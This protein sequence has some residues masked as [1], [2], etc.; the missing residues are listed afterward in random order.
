M[1]IITQKQISDLN[2]SPKD[3]VEWVKGSFAAK[4]KSNLPAKTCLYT[5]DIDFFTTM[6]CVLFEQNR[7]GVKVVHR[8]SGAVPALGSDLM[9]YDLSNGDLLAIMDANWITAMR[10]GA[11]ATLAAQT[12][13]R[14]GQVT[15]GFMGLGNTARASMLCLL[16]SEPDIMHNVNLLK[17][18]NQE[19]DFIK[20]FEGYSNVSFSFYGDVR[21][22]ISSTDVL[23]SCITEAKTL[24]C[25]DDQAY[26]KGCLLIP[27]HTRGFQN[28]D[29]TF[30]KIFADD[31]QHVKGF[32]YFSQFRRYAEIQDVLSGKV[33]GRENDS[34]RIISY[35][36]GLG[37]HDVYFASRIFDLLK[38]NS[39]D[40]PFIKETE[41]FWI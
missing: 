27:I 5:K 16:E 36:V 17:Y 8:I 20:R 33:Q 2:I 25:D 26:R 39:L 15:Y 31:T 22:M 41:K 6:P 18:K 24:V 19:E 28:C 7:F 4:E 14:S 13:R 32:K 37:L 11:V 10:T 1:K 35:N 23:F 3:C 38:D 29:L 9:L 12:F 34:E 21:E 40:L 30:D